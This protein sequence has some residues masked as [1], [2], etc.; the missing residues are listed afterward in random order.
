VST[1]T[2]HLHSMTT[3]RTVPGVRSLVAR[4]ASGSFGIQAGHEDFMTALEFGLARYRSGA[5][6]WQYLA[7][8]GGI[9]RVAAGEVW[10]FTRR[11][12]E[13][14]D[15]RRLGGELERQLRAEEEALRETRV[16][17][18]QMEQHLLRRLWELEQRE[19]PA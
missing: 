7:L 9:L 4:D 10:L 15:Y 6:D 2:L 17:L 3:A 13:D 11:Y 12:L 18:Q 8:P 5:N 16:S 14:S 1:F 19:S